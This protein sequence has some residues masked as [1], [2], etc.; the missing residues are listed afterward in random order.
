VSATPWGESYDDL[1]D[2]V[3]ADKTA[4]PVLLLAAFLYRHGDEK[5]LR[6]LIGDTAALT[7]EEPTP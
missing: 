1:A 7:P 4:P 6:K 3:L 2:A 5:R